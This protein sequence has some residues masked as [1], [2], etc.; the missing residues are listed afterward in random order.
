MSREVKSTV[1]EF[2]N[3]ISDNDLLFVTTRLADRCAGD[4]AEAL[5]FLSKQK[6]V[7]IILSSAHSSEE[8]YRTLDMVADVLRQ[9]CEKKG[10]FNSAA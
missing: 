1:K 3:T 9:E 4:L 10:L 7:D 2:A 5:D 8:F 6:N